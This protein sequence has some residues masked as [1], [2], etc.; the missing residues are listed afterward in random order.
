M[1]L[2]LP[3]ATSPAPAGLS[4]RPALLVA[5]AMLGTFQ[6]APAAQLTL[7]QL[8]QSFN[9]TP[10]A[11][12]VTT[13][14]ADLPVALIYQNLALNPTPAGSEV[15]FNNTPSSLPLSYSSLSFAATKANALGN[16]IRLGGTARKLVSC[17]ATMVTW[18][19]ASKYPQLAALNPN[20]YFHPV[21]LTLYT[22]GTDLKLTPLTE[23]TANILVPWRP[24][25]LPN[26]SP[27]PYNGYAFR[28]HFE[29]TGNVI[30]TEQILATISYD[31]QSTGYSPLRVPGPYN[32][33]NVALDGLRPS[34]GQ[35]VD[36]DTVLRVTDEAWYYPNTGW[37][38]SNGPSVRITASHA[39][40]KTPPTHPGTY[41]V[42]AIGGTTGTEGKTEALFTVAPPTLNSW[43]EKEF[44]PE[45]IAA[46]QSDPYFDADGDGYS[47]LA[48]YALG[49]TPGDSSSNPNTGP[50]LTPDPSGMAL[51]LVRPRWLTGV[52]Y[53]A[54]ESDDLTNWFPVPLEPVTSTESTE[55]VKASVSETRRTSNHAFLRVRFVP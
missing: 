7:S 17:D 4:H 45:Q 13:I 42:T 50:A 16:Y 24:E 38:N 6:P 21:S 10:I 55:T 34:V 51:T 14:P 20:G 29:F 23:A 33:L 12:A 40:T 46:G 18:A 36:A 22:V 25:T 28:A 41:K 37:S 9:G 5:A 30:L 44:T 2:S 32:E 19:R 49:T 35:D 53:I 39:A 26:G 11:P 1:R 27:Y 8:L 15:V 43:K 31:T 3:P 47:N 52:Q 48:E 54:E